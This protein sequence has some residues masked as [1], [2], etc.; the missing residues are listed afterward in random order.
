MEYKSIPHILLTSV[1]KYSS[2]PAMKYKEEGIYRDI[3]YLELLEK[4]KNFSGGLAS[5]GI[6]KDNKVSILSENRPEWAISDYAILSLGAITVPVYPSLT[7]VQIDYI[8]RNSESKI[9]IISTD[10]L[11]ERVSEIVKNIPMI[12]NIVMFEGYEKYQDKKILSLQELYN[13]G[14]EYNK[15]NPGQFEKIVEQI[16]PSNLA[17][18][19]YTSGTTGEPKGVML[20]HNNFISNILS[21]ISVLPIS[22]EDTFLSFL[23]LCH[24]FERMA[25]HFL[26]I[27]VGSTIAYAEGID[28]VAENMQEIHPTVMTSVPR[29]YEKMY[30]KVKEAVEL[31]SPIKRKLFNWSFSVGEEYQKKKKSNQLNFGTKFKF[32]FAN[33]LVFSKLKNR[34]GDRIRFF[35]SGGAPLPG[36]IGEFFEKAGILILE[37]YGLTETSPVISV[38]R[39]E[40]YK[41]GTV[42]LPIPGVDVKIADDGEILTKGPHVMLGYYKNREE[43]ERTIDSEGW[44]HTGDIGEIDEDGF[45]KITDR[46]K[47]LIVTSLGKNVAPQPI[48][49]LLV[50]NKYIEQIMLIG[51]KRKFISALIVPNFENINRYTKEIG[52]AYANNTELVNAPEVYKLIENEIE[53]ISTDLANFE[54]VKKFTLLDRELTIDNGELTP[55]LKI[56]RNVVEKKFKDLI[57]KMYQ[58]A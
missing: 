53:S 31:G 55:T 4:I 29:L 38:N 40:K 44:F 11:Y 17:S 32:N 14:E 35:V 33:K 41:F 21:S 13:K 52:L 48:E 37:G 16:E 54:K 12:E 34:V 8:L 25:G 56:K 15:S 28:K 45:L 2:K 50:T 27:T 30:A 58:E 20:T 57:D 5:I 49:N 39:E 10:E 23:P 51:D 18:I 3:S 19:I 36:E 43:T 26:P 22:D 47:N 1:E 24:V 6:K 46:K 42:G 9:L 7:P